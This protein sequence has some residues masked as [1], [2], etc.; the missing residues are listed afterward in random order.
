MRIDYFDDY[1]GGEEIWVG[2]D[3]HGATEYIK[4]AEVIEDGWEDGYIEDHFDNRGGDAIIDGFFEHVW[5]SDNIR[6]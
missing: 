6:I 5:L 4:E 2:H 3:C 1:D